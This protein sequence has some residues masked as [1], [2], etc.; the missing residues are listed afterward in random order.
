M[1]ARPHLSSVRQRSRARAIAGIAAALSASAPDLTPDEVA[2]IAA[3][4]VNNM[5]TM[6][7]MTLGDAPTSPGAPEEL[8]LM[9]RLYLADRLAPG[10]NC[11]KVR[12]ADLP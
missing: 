3:V 10:R 1:E 12:L 4:L 11:G 9:N 8:R 5:K 7:A 2:A 6:L